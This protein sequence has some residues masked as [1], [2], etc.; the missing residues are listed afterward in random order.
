MTIAPNS[1]AEDLL[2]LLTGGVI[3]AIS[4]R[5]NES[6]AERQSR[7]RIALRQIEEYE[8]GDGVEIMLAG[9]VVLFQNLA[10]D[11]VHDAQNATMPDD[12]SKL[13]QQ[14]MALGRVQ[15][16]FLAQLT[17]RQARRAKLAAEEKPTK[18]APPLKV[19]ADVPVA[20]ARVEPE[21]R[22]QP[23]S[24]IP[25]GPPVG[26]IQTPETRPFSLAAMKLAIQSAP[27]RQP[28]QTPPHTGAAA[29][30]AGT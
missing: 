28:P 19:E 16:G 9:Q 25:P 3:K 29:I 14:A 23:S 4:D 8:P 17:R 2:L 10:L 27:T 20:P 30:A 13:R 18:I 26:A 6:L 24:P 5:P 21:P 11:A 15:M 1:E 12:A 7:A 22:A